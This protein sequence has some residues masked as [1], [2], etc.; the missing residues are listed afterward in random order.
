MRYRALAAVAVTAALLVAGCGDDNDDTDV[1]PATTVGDQDRDQERDRDQDRD[2]DQIHQL[3]NDTLDACE[4][5][6]RDRLRDMSRDH[7]HDDL[8]HADFITDDD[9]TFDVLDQDVTVDGDS[10]TADIHLRVRERGDDDQVEQ[11]M[12]WRFHHDGA[13]W[14]LDDLPACVE[15]TTTPIHHDNDRDD[16]RDD[17]HDD[18]DD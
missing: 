12:N 14:R 1:E 16:D 17:R 2:R 6:D 11:D 15:G 10:A 7:V 13:G 8:E 4:D 18:N 5:R 9:I 3:I